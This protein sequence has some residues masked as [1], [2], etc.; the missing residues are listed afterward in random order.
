[1]TRRVMLLCAD[2]RVPAASHVRRRTH[3]SSER[4]PQV[5]L[6]LSKNCDSDH[7]RHAHQARSLYAR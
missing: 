2:A 3:A 6:I 5:D 1:M 4:E 7:E